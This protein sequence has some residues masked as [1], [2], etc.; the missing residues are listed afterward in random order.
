MAF[1]RISGGS[2]GLPKLIPHTHDDDIYS[3]RAS[4]EI[5][6]LGPESVFMAALAVAHDF[7]MSSP[8]FFGTLHAG[9]RVVLCPNPA[10]ET[11]FALIAREGVG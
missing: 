5:C 6:G 2:T 10:P 1:L 4:A 3:F 8:G 11:A 7:T 9:G